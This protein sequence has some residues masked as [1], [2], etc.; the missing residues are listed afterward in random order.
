MLLEGL[1]VGCSPISCAQTTAL[2]SPQGWEPSPNH[3]HIS[4]AASA[5]GSLCALCLYL[6]ALRPVPL[7]H[8][9]FPAVM[10][11]GGGRQ[12]APPA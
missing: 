12:P 3:P 4:A 1:S 10:V 6:Q 11:A 7:S 5:Q 8:P 9:P 2:Q